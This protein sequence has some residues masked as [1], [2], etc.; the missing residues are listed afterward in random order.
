MIFSPPKGI[1]ITAIEFF[2]LRPNK[3]KYDEP[4]RE[5]MAGDILQNV[6]VRGW[7]RIGSYLEPMIHNLPDRYR[8]ALIL[9]GLEG[10]LQKVVADMLELSLSGSK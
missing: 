1:K 6:F 10:M 9:S 4:C 5:D 8:Q 7:S 2:Q 3:P